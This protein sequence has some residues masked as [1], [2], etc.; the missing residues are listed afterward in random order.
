MNQRARQQKRSHV[1]TRKRPIRCL[2]HGQE[3]DSVQMCKHEKEKQ[4][5]VGRC[6]GGHRGRGE[7]K[8]LMSVTSYLMC[9]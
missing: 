2:S 6:S 5:G 3:N 8:L 4:F 7:N 1:Y 9:E